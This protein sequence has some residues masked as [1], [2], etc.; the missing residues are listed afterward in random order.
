MW[1]AG[2]GMRFVMGWFRCWDVEF[3]ECSRLG[4]DI[5]YEYAARIPAAGLK[6]VTQQKR[7]RYFM[8][9]SALTGYSSS[10]IRGHWFRSP[11]RETC[12]VNN[13]LFMRRARCHG[14]PTSDCPTL[15]STV[16]RPINQTHST[17]S[18]PFGQIII[19]LY[20]KCEGWTG[21][22]TRDRPPIGNGRP[23]GR[24]QQSDE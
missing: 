12:P 11:L 6:M 2:C 5:V 9:C 1:D 4:F 22:R 23:I 14:R 15:R 8:A 7:W 20:V 10:A 3:R 18:A 24:A 16:H 13:A 21:E 17:G 19:P